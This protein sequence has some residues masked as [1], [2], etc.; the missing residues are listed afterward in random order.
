MEMVQ[1]QQRGCRAVFSSPAASCSLQQLQSVFCRSW[2]HAWCSSYAVGA[3]LVGA[4]VWTLAASLQRIEDAVATVHNPIFAGEMRQDLQ[5]G[6]QKQIC[7]HLLQCIAEF[8]TAASPL[9][10]QRRLQA[11]LESAVRGAVLLNA[12][13]AVFWRLHCLQ[14]KLELC[15]DL[16]QISAEFKLPLQA[17]ESPKHCRFSMQ[18]CTAYCTLQYSLQPPLQRKMLQQEQGKM[19]DVKLKLA[20][21]KAMLEAKQKKCRK[22]EERDESA[23]S[24]ADKAVE[25]LL[26]DP[27]GKPRGLEGHGGL[28][29]WTL[30]Q[31]QK[32]RWLLELQQVES[33]HRILAAERRLRCGAPAWSFWCS[34]VPEKQAAESSKL[35]CLWRQRQQCQSRSRCRTLLL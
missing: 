25:S 32:R 27:V 9:W 11:V 3:V 22:A 31:M 1:N 2:S 19:K 15:T 29:W 17:M 21:K 35:S 16:L 14:E 30:R 18:G 33:H 8:R 23:Q 28:H 4:G 20:E 26:K 12:E 6:L 34:S 13:G 7:R 5:T 24:L 10:L